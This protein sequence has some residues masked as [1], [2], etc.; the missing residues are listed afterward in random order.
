[1]STNIGIHKPSFANKYI[2]ASSQF[3]VTTH[4][5]R[6][7]NP[8]PIHISSHCLGTNSDESS[9]GVL[10]LYFLGLAQKDVEH[11]QSISDIHHPVKYA[12]NQNSSG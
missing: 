12:K 11:Y 1:M 7:K 8:N 4:L 2:S 9:F 5:F 10:W 3:I 6:V